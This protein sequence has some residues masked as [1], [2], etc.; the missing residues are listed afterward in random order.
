MK[1]ARVHWVAGEVG[2]DGVD[3]VGVFLVCGVFKVDGLVV[4]DGVVC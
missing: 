4:M 2:M 1:N 3:L